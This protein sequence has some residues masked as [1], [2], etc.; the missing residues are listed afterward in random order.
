MC[1]G[2][3]GAGSAHFSFRD[4]LREG[5]CGTRRESDPPPE[6]WIRRSTELGV[7]LGFCGC[8]QVP[9]QEQ[10][11]CG[12]LAGE[13]GREMALASTFVPCQTELCSPGA[14]Q[15]SLPLSSSPLVL[16]AELL[17]YNLP[18]VKSRLLLEHTASGPSAFASQTQGL[19]LASRQ[20]LRSGS[21]LPVRVACT[22]SLPF[23]PSSVG[24]LSALGSGDS[25]LLVFWQFSGLFRPV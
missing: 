21:L 24:L 14:Q 11:P 23:L 13:W 19:C 5:P 2:A 20:P 25:I 6:G 7:C 17:T 16:Q 4:P 22:A 15:L 3:G 18:D 12:I 9:W 1:T 10:V 8:K